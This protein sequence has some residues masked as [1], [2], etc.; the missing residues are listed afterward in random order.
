MVQLAL[1]AALADVEKH[2]K[3]VRVTFRVRVRLLCG[4]GEK[5]SRLGCALAG[6]VRVGGSRYSLL[7]SS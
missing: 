2:R 3:E 5:R 1:A 6:V 7:V 4:G